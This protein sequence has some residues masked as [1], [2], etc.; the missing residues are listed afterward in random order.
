MQQFLVKTPREIDYSIADTFGNDYFLFLWH[1]WAKLVAGIAANRWNG[2]HVLRCVR[3][4]PSGC[5][6]RFGFIYIYLSSY[7]QVSF[8]TCLESYLKS[9]S[10]VVFL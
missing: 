5:F 1:F 6:K 10:V 2:G 7:M 3:P 4:Q 9:K 8:Y